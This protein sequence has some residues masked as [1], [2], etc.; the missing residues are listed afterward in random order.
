MA[1]KIL[2]HSQAAYTTEAITF[3]VSGFRSYRAPVNDLAIGLL[4]ALLATNP[5]TAVSNLI[6]KKTGLAVAVANP[7]D[8]VEREFKKLMAE[9]D[10]AHEQVDDWIQE[11][12]KDEQK[13]VSLRARIQ[14]RL[15]PIRKAYEKYLATHPGHAKALLAYG[16]FLNDQGEEEAAEKQWNKALAADPKEP[17][18]WNNLANFYGH[19]G[20]A[21]KAIEY[22]GKAITLD[23]EESTY[24]HNLA[25]TVF[26]FRRDATNFFKLSE[27][28]VFDKSLDLY[29]KAIA[30]DP[31]NFFLVSDYA[32]S[33]YALK[34]QR[35]DDPA[36]NK[37]AEQKLVDDALSAWRMAYKIA[38]GNREQQGVVIHFARWEINGARYGQARKTLDSITNETLQAARSTLLKRLDRQT[39]GKGTNAP[40]TP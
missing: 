8:P 3:Y 9:D 36:K 40:A 21:A 12:Y 16:S 11:S 22:Y 29:R 28:D 33:Y 39:Q 4:S 14:Q 23:P 32:Q 13:K 1:R 38:P 34:P 5:P 24:Y 10:A 37:E 6:Q 31:T 2:L 27:A 30:L 35:F 7:N 19:N 26:V 17:A 15:D 20:N 25:T 18:A